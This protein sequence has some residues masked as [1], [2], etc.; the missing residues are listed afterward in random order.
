MVG[1][2]NGT[3]EAQVEQDAEDVGGAQGTRQAETSGTGAG[4]GND[5]AG[6]TNY[7]RAI[8]ERDARIAKLEAQVAEA[9]KSAQTADELRAQIAELKAQGESDRI[10]FALQLAGARNLKAA[11]AVLADHD[12]DVEALVAAEP[13][14]FSQAGALLNKLLRIFP[15]RRAWS[16]PGPPAARASAT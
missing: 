1:D 5:A 4:M 9:A 10:D 11:R 3:E 14:L 2:S 12:G 16:P 7:E 6:E 13:W 8:G 15:A